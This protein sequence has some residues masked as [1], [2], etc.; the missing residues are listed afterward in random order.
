MFIM[1]K[2]FLAV[3]LLS[4]LT[5]GATINKAN[6]KVAYTA[7]TAG[8]VDFTVLNKVGDKGFVILDSQDQVLGYSDTGTFDYDKMPENFK[9]W[10][11]QYQEQINWA[12]NNGVQSPKSQA[13]SDSDSIIVQPLL[14]ET[15]WS[16]GLPYCIYCPPDGK[17]YSV[18]GCVATAMA[19]IMYYHKWPMRGHGYHEYEWNGNTISRNFSESTYDWGNMLPKYRSGEYTDEQGKAVARLCADAGISVNM[20]YSAS[21]SGTQSQPISPAFI[22]YF[23]YSSKTHLLTQNNMPKKQW[24]SIIVAELDAARPV[25]YCGQDVSGMGGH[26]FV[27]DGYTQ[28][29]FFH[30]NWGWSGSG[31]GYFKTG[32]LNVDGYKFNTYNDITIGVE[33]RSTVLVDGLCYEIMSDSTVLFTYGDD[34]DY[35]DSVVVPEEVTIDSIT[36]KVSSLT[37]GCLLQQVITPSIQVPWT[38]PPAAERVFSDLL[39]KNTVLIVP[40]NCV[41]IYVNSPGWNKFKCIKDTIGHSIEWGEW[42]PFADGTGTYI[43]SANFFLDPGTEDPGLPISCRKSKTNEGQW[44]FWLQHWSYDTDLYISYDSITGNCIIPKQYAGY[45]V[46]I[47]GAET[48]SVYISDIPN[49]SSKYT[50]E[51]YPCKYDAEKGL[52]TLNVLYQCGGENDDAYQNHGVE[53]FQVDG[54]VTDMFATY[55]YEKTFG[56]KI[57]VRITAANGIK[58]CKY[59]FVEGEISQDSVAVV[60]QQIADSLIESKT[61]YIGLS[62]YKPASLSKTY[63][64]VIAGFG[65]NGDFRNYTS[66]IVNY[67]DIYDMKLGD[68]NKDDAID[69]SDITTTAAYILG[70]KPTSFNRFSADIDK[71]GVITVADITAL[72]AMIL[73]SE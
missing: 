24:D 10:L 72:A 63:T 65:K 27:C 45:E 68:A 73:G 18:V 36:Y 5:C 1:K 58:S 16:Q 28:E 39:Y 42:E 2:L 48:S 67:N 43:Y 50:Y 21:G 38:T 11:S 69:V 52:F 47:D 55:D 57:G 40:D 64:M 3:A 30:F 23:G 33:P 13:L 7:K 56:K 12:R 34:F 35:T 6:M 70:N 54:F 60:A 49:F 44:Q 29:G 62:T 4:A 26:A 9:W 51:E 14:G 22:G 46:F 25:L 32:A 59:V 41:E 71:D 66:T 53:T 17:Y 37:P 19:Q 8:K 31:N 20:N 61:A 15:E